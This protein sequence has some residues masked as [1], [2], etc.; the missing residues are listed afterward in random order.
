MKESRRMN[1]PTADAVKKIF[2]GIDELQNMQ[3]VPGKTKREFTIDGRLVGDIGEAAAEE[4]YAIKLTKKSKAR[5]DAICTDGKNKGKE[6]QIKATFKDS[7]TFKKTYRNVLYLGFK[8]DG[9]T[10]TFEEIYNGT[11]LA[12]YNEFKHRK[13]PER[14]F[15]IPTGKLE[16]IMKGQ[17]KGRS[18]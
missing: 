14:L 3:K 11:G 16:E 8:L 4:N 12:I 15:S 13:N 9:K 10:G 1:K 18:S 7:L 2:E 5:Y 6:V 17:D